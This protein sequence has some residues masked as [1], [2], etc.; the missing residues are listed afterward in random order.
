[1]STP[2]ELLANAKVA[3][4]RRGPRLMK[5]LLCMDATCLAAREAGIAAG[6]RA[7]QAGVNYVPLA[8]TGEAACE[9]CGTIWPVLPGPAPAQA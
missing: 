3:P 2:A 5:L 1:M 7:A 6:T 9:T 8:L 4:L